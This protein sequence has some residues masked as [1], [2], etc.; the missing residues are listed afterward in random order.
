[1]RNFGALTIH[2][3]ETIA[4]RSAVE[5]IFRCSHLDNKDLFSK[6]VCNCEAD[7]LRFYI[8]YT[9]IFLSVSDS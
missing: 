3:E 2:A 9:Y 8:T 5:M 1:M 4:S 7:T 6:S